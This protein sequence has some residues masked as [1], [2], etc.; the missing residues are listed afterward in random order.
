MTFHEKL[1]ILRKEKGL[2]QE[3]LA[4]AL[5]VSRQAI[6]KWESG[7]S[8][9]ETENL[10]ALSGVLGV[11]LDSLLKDGEPQ[12]GGGYAIPYRY[13]YR[14]HYEYMS[15]KTLHGLPLVHINIGLGAYKAKGIIA[16]G[17][18]AQGLVAVGLLSMGG[19]SVGLLSLGLVGVGLLAIGALAVGT[20]AAG[21]LAVGAMAAGVF[22]VGALSAGMYSL[23]A[24]AVGTRVAVGDHAHAPIAVGRVVTGSRQFVTDS[25]GFSSVSSWEVRQA[26]L[27]DFP[28]TWN[29]VI[30]MLTW[31]MGA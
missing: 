12:S 9:P 23:G 2:S 28:G 22:A 29:I 13:A 24:L 16:V 25:R 5:G 6:S 20:L 17:T 18:I 8:Y 3:A 19:L 4:E 15:R 21:I 26:I 11:T 1:Q 27:R 10:I 31:F 30:R 14:T 7:Q